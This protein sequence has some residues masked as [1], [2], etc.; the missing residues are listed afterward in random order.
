MIPTRQCFFRTALL[1]TLLV[2]FGSR[3]SLYAQQPAATDSAG[4]D[5]HAG[6]S[7]ED[8]MILK[9][10]DIHNVLNRINNITAQGFSTQLIEGGLPEIQGGLSAIDKNLALYSKVLNIRNLQTYRVLLGD[11]RRQLGSW[12]ETLFGYNRDLTKM[13]AD[14]NAFRNDSSIHRVLRD[15][16]FRQL[17][18]SELQQLLSKGR[19]ARK[20]INDD[21]QRI[22]KLQALVSNSY[23]KSMEL[24]NKLNDQLRVFSIRTS[25]QEYASL[26]DARD[27]KENAAMLEMTRKSY[28]GEQKII[29]YYFN[30]HKGHWFW[31]FLIGF[32]FFYW[33]FKGFRTIKASGQQ[34]VLADVHFRY[35]RSIPILATL[36]VMLNVAPFFDL[37]PPSVYVELM[38]FFLLITLT[39]LFWRNWPRRVFLYYWLPIFFLNLA[40]PIFNKTTEPGATLRIWMLVMQ[41][42][43]VVFGFFFLN[44]ARKAIELH[45]LVRT[46]TIVYIVFNILAI[47]MNLFG[48][49][50]LSGVYGT[51]AILGFTQIIGMSI[52]TSII[53]EA[54]YLQ[55]KKSRISGGVTAKFNYEKIKNSLDRILSVIMFI[56]WIIIFTTNLNFYND[57]YTLFDLLLTTSRKIGTTSFTLGNILLFFAVIFIANILQKYIGYFFGETEDDFV[58]EVSKKG[59][60]LVLMRLIVLLVGFLIAIAASGLPVDKVTVVLGALGVGIGLGLQNIVNNLVSGMILIFERPL[61]VGDFV[62]VGARQGRVR[63]IG[64]RSSKLVTAAGAEVIV[65]NGDL[66]SGQLVNWT[67]RNNHIRTE[68]TLKLAPPDRL[69]EAKAIILQEIEQ[70]NEVLNRPAV[71]ILI[72]NITAA[73]VEIK[74]QVW[75]QT[76]GREQVVRSEMLSRIYNRLKENDITVQ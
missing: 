53:T 21:L 45:R 33:V 36:V 54:F 61:Q 49:F 42:L 73:V 30:H 18:I 65:P 44:K 63:D 72:T 37:N 7:P 25:G 11:M 23:F 68:L 51:A 75:L 48:R 3:L 24:E 4:R 43:S 5:N 46:V 40:I 66:L 22:N 17:Y 69:D 13:T 2:T 56:G 50:S 39:L 31:F 76:V 8:S 15:T 1:I 6:L 9:I 12:R 58:G 19:Q 10:E 59:S 62:E 28:E 29:A 70:I 71:E 14:M 55:M 52:F 41:I 67:L 74:V 32:I 16:A 20:A 60:K 47:L 27:T 57:L 38:Q 35:L 34:D 64:I 26:W